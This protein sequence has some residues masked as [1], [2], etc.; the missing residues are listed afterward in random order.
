MIDEKPKLIWHNGA[1]VP[2]ESATVHVTSE[3]AMRGLS[4]FEGLRGYWH[5]DAGRLAL[6]RLAAHLERL[7]VSA[8]LMHIPSEGLA[9][10]IRAGILE[11]LKELDPRHD[12]YLR[13][14]LY[15]DTGRY[16]AQRNEVTTGVWVACYPAGPRP[17]EPLRC[18]VSRW[19]RI[20]DV[21]MP[22]AAKVG[23][24]YTAFR[25]ARLEALDAGA[26]EAILLNA[27]GTVAETG[28]AAVFTVRRGR[29]VTPPLADGLLDS[30]TRR[31]VIDLGQSM[32]I[33]VAEQPVTRSD[34]YT[35]DEVFVAGTLDEVRIVGEVDGHRP[36]SAG[37]PI[38][39]TVRDAYLRMCA[40][41]RL[42]LDDSFLEMTP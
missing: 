17:A 26:D 5:Q 1:V 24:A 33:P 7:E 19:Q 27:A 11:L 22:T 21:A 18:V 20:P 34:L 36:R 14:T 12:V 3:T 31:T 32:G 8:Q 6:V 28:G 23:A 13:P 38:G 16:T 30:I 10:Q 4:V 41:T 35:A 40:G 2:W 15:V 9:K 29:I 37:S 25:L 42:P 39:T